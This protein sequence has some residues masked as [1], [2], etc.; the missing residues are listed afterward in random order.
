MIRMILAAFGM[1]VIFSVIPHHGASALG[2][3]VAPLEYKTTLKEGEQKQG[4]VDV[5]NP[6]S[7]IVSVRTSV[8]AFKQI[9]DDGGLQFYDDQAVAAGVKPELETFELGPREA[10]RVFFTIDGNIL[11]EGDIYAAL[12][13]T[14]EPKQA[15]NGL[16]QLV[17]VGTILSI[18][19]KTPGDRSA[20]VTG[21]TLPFLQLSDTLNGT[22]RIKNTGKE[23]TG[24]YPTVR[25][26][27][28]PGSTTKNV[29]SS[30]V[31]G[32]RERSNDFTL[33]SGYGIH[34]V[35][36]GYGDSKK[37]Q[38]VIAVAP[39]MLIGLLLVIVVVGIELLL[40]KKRRK[41]KPKK[42]SKS[43]PSTPEK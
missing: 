40:L 1:A 20:K 36:I 14:T 13:L 37:S 29:E 6:S 31:F 10:L 32:G 21:L 28:L 12:F 18:V 3:K 39:W 9:D 26:V 23:G 8:Q 42:H 11:P 22:Y 35:E 15:Q 17:R 5:S 38:W 7:Q 41:S 25:A 34:N 19:N 30:L 43:H 16:G 2:L 24:F 27:S 4:F 33:S